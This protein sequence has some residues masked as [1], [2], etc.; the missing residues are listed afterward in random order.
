MVIDV[1]KRQ[2]CTQKLHACAFTARLCVAEISTAPVACTIP[3]RRALP[4]PF[5]HMTQNEHRNNEW[6]HIRAKEE[7]LPPLVVTLHAHRYPNARSPEHGNHQQPEKYFHAEI[8]QPRG[9]VAHP[10]MVG[11]V[12]FQRNSPVVEPGLHRGTAGCAST[13]RL[14][15][16]RMKGLF[17]RSNG[18]IPGKCFAVIANVS[19]QRPSMENPCPA[20]ASPSDEADATK[21]ETDSNRTDRAAAS[22][23]LDLRLDQGP[24]H[25]CCHQLGRS[26]S[27]RCQ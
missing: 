13:A 11:G 2:I 25:G 23:K 3:P 7:T 4:L 26:I 6:P 17:C 27:H 5:K 24:E 10:F 8:L 9:R 22:M 18:W 15:Q 19:H 1:G 14:L 21:R 16:H 12:E 20:H